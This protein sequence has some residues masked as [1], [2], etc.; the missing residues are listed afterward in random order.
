V[1]RSVPR[2]GVVTDSTA[3]FPAAAH[4]RLGIEVVPL[5]VTWDGDTFR[6]KVDLTTADFY[7]MLPRRVSVP[8]TSAPAAGLFEAAY[9][10]LLGR[11]DHV[12][13]IH[14]AE[15][16]SATCDIAR[17]AAER[18]GGGRVTVIDSRQTTMCLAWLAMRAA[19]L[20]GQGAPLDQILDEVHAWIPRLRLYAV[21]G[22]LEYLKKGGRIGRAQ[23]LMGALLNIKPLLAVR[24]GE[25]HPVERVRS[26]S[27]A[28]RRLVDVVMSQGK[29]LRVGILHGG[30]PEVLEQLE[31]L[32]TERLPGQTF[33]RTEIGIVLGTHAG[34][35]VM[36]AAC[37][38]E[39]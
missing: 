8:K 12:I 36:G 19:E 11:V 14:L 13:S 23:A 9:E 31:R 28:M 22:T 34:P 15:K 10:R 33:E 29:P 24:D 2:I 5:S 37:L 21:L 1:S 6:D 30:M 7:A 39:E 25:V 26:S 20:G 17:G 35:G 18:V 32:F 38:L 27:A 4:E 16:L 3:D